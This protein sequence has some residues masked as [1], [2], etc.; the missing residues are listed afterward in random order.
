[1]LF[2]DAEKRL[3][4]RVFRVKLFWHLVFL[5]RLVFCFWQ[6]E[7][8]TEILFQTW[9]P[10]KYQTTKH[11]PSLSHWFPRAIN[12][13]WRNLWFLV[14]EQTD[15]WKNTC[16][17]SSAKMVDL[18]L[19]L[20]LNMGIAWFMPRFIGKMMTND[21]GIRWLKGMLFSLYDGHG[22]SGNYVKSMYKSP[23]S[24]EQIAVSQNSLE[25]LQ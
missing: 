23:F 17:Y 9:T 6:N 4:F 10:Q 13:P 18:D 20:G 11:Y 24:D 7:N 14:G 15:P 25:I 2:E 5:L 3:I 19:D 21:R 22:R 8:P 1:M 16:H 12:P